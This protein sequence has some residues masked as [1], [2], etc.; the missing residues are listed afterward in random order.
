[1]AASLA[2]AFLSGCLVGPDYKRPEVSVPATLGALPPDA[3]QTADTE[4][5]KQFD[6]PVLD[7]LIAEALANNKDL[8]IA[9]ANVEQAAGL[10]EQTRSPLFPQI[11][12]TANGGRYRYSQ[13]STGAALAVNPSNAYNVL[14]GASWEL[15]LW[16]RI[17]R[18]SESAQAQLLAT[19]EA[20]RGVVLTLV[21]QV[22]TSYVQLR[23]LDEQLVVA[24]RTLETYKE[25]L[26][27]VQ[28]KFQ[29]GQVS[30]MNVAQVQSQV[31]TAQAR[32]PQLRSQIKQ[33]ENALA[34]LLGRN[35]GTIPRGKSVL[36]LTL[37]AV[38]AGVPSQLLE[39]RP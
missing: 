12:Y 35:P 19:E 29:F 34:I 13:Q 14:A 7:R 21:A 30:K 15:D 26:R 1:M 9:A 22:A 27:I 23:A 36:A 20:R 32:I 17:R 8:R 38:P 31:E 10:L 33:T 11:D 3:A 18:L 16:G 28:D 4:W 25:S 2:A 39:R 6:D 5:W 24:L 37:P